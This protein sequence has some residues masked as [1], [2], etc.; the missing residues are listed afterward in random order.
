MFFHFL[1]ISSIRDI[2]RR[3]SVSAQTRMSW[4]RKEGPEP[5]L[6]K[7]Q[8]DWLGGL[9]S[10]WN[11]MMLRK[12]LEFLRLEWERWKDQWNLPWYSD[13]HISMKISNL[14]EALMRQ[15][16]EGQPLNGES[17]TASV[18]RLSAARAVVEKR[19]RESVRRIHVSSL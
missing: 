8:F 3:A 13:E 19:A 5:S 1:R 7:L 6:M 10:A 4:E 9:K 17:I 16:K 11:V 12:L 14:F 15:W 2:R 18:E